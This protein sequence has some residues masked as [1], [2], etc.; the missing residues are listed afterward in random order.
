MKPTDEAKRL[1]EELIVMNTMKGMS[2]DNAERHA[3][4]SINKV[5]D[6]AIDAIWNECEKIDRC[7]SE[8][9]EITMAVHKLRP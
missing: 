4:K 7:L 8:A 2:I 3:N 5:L 6:A 9:E 1:R